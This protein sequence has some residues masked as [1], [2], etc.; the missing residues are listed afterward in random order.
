MWFASQVAELLLR[1]WTSVNAKFFRA[2]C[3]KNCALDRK[4]D[5]TFFDRTNVNARRLKVRKCGI[6]LVFLSCS[7]SGEQCVRGVHSSHKHCVAVYYPIST[8]FSMVFHKQLLFRK[9]YL[10]RIFAAIWRH[11]F[12]EIAV[13]NCEKS[14]NRRKS[15]CAPLPPLH[16][17][18]W[19]IWKI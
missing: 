2:P 7:E 9:H 13:K 18:S 19:R 10:V 8:R 6:S 14:Q 15:L 1:N 4:M 17:D 3:R 5:N 11:N 16:I 12:R